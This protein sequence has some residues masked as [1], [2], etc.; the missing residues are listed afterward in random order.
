MAV[1][2]NDAPIIPD[3]RGG[4]IADI[5]PA[6]LGSGDPRQRLSSLPADISEARAVVLLVLDGLGW[7]QFLA[8]R[9]F[10]PVLSTFSGGALTTVAPSTTATALTSLTTGL[11]PSEHGVIGYRMHMGESVMNVLRWGDVDGDCRRKYPPTSVQPC[12]PFL[13]HVVPV[14][15]KAEFENTG[16]TLAHLD[17][18]RHHG[19]RVASS[20]AVEVERIIE[21][22]EKF[23]YAYYDG[24]DK[25]AH[26]KGFGQYYESELLAADRIVAS[27]LE[28]L[29]RD[30]VLLV[31]ADHGQVSVGGNIITLSSEM[32]E[33]VETMSGEGRFRWLHAK[34]GAASSLLGSCRDGFGSLAWVASIEQ[35]LDEQWFGP[36]PVADVRRRM[37]DVA[38]VPFDPVSFADPHDGENDL[39]CRHGSL[40]ADEMLVPLVAHVK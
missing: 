4:C 35:I 22:G 25:I 8:H 19:W 33:M 9:Q 14:V 18:V 26:A 1:T 36:P 7:N 3:Y 12:P 6:L 27:V 16:F 28:V 5:I 21:S 31:T 39:V 2:H 30:A 37:G 24:I 11:A 34:R 10:L 20:I 15:S 40:T 23:V 32:L 29:P 17:G 13:G 38:L